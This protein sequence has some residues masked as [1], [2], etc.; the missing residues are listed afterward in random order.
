[1]AKV[2]DE[3]S[4]MDFK[5][6]KIVQGLCVAV[7]KV[8][9]QKDDQKKQK[10]FLY[11]WNLEKI[12]QISDNKYTLVGKVEDQ[13]KIIYQEEG[14]EDQF[15][16][17]REIQATNQQIALLTESNQVLIISQGKSKGQMDCR[18]IYKLNEIEKISA[19]GH[20]LALQKEKKPPIA[21]WQNQD[22]VEF[23]N[24]IGLEDYAFQAKSQKVVGADIEEYDE[25][26]WIINFGIEEP[27]ELQKLRYEISK[28]KN[29]RLIK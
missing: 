21:V 8:N 11:T 13:I 14:K 17:F 10:E 9:F 26:Y 15:A 1:M 22:V 2:E 18:N 28:H 4:E 6:I 25:D 20:F 16:I 29:G 23:L 5:L 7:I 3:G 12:A 27:S 24:E 19:H